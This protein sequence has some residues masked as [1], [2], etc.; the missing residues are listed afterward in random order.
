MN[1]RFIDSTCATE[2]CEKNHS[3]IDFDSP[4]CENG[5]KPKAELRIV[6]SKTEK[7][8]TISMQNVIK[9]NNVLQQARELANKLDV[10]IGRTSDIKQILANI[11]TKINKL[12]PES[13]DNQVKSL[14]LSYYQ[15]TYNSI[16]HESL[17]MLNL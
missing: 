3:L 11:S 10:E 12:R 8:K 2:N 6:Y 9:A 13:L 7:P 14:K 16:C 1:S 15:V 4:I 17:D 5:R